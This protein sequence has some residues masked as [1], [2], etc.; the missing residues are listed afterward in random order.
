V[1]R[2]PQHHGQLLA[3]AGGECQC[4]HTQVVVGVGVLLLG[5]ACS[6]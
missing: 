5:A 1:A 2:I 6:V 4:Q 3:P